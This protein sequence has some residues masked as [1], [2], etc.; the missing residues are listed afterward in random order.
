MP[1]IDWTN[2]NEVGVAEVDAQHQK[3][4]ELLNRLHESVV[5]GK[6]QTELHAILDELIEYTVYHF[7]T[8]ETLLLD[9]GYPGFQT[10]KKAHDAL[11]RTAVDLQNEMREG[12]AMLSFE[13]L[14]FLHSWL[15]D[16]TIGLD[17]EM[18]PYLN[19]KGIR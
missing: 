17:R 12:S 6:E 16:H 13:L 18:G 4:F 5:Q 8:E 7:K 3:L 10:Q 1:F 15:M 2:K 9:T 14:D 11:T 19:A